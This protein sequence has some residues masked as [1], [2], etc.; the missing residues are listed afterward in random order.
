MKARAEKDGIIESIEKLE[1][2]EHLEVLDVRAKK[3][4]RLTKKSRPGLGIKK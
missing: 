4:R 3:R 2:L 1:I